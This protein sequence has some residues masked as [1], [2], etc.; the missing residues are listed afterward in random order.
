VVASRGVLY[1]VADYER[2]VPVL[3]QVQVEAGVTGLL[4]ARG[5]TV[6]RDAAL[7]RAGLRHGQRYSPLHIR[8]AT[9]VHHALAGRRSDSPAAGTCGSHRIEAVSQALVGSARRKAR[10][11]RSRPTAWRCC[12]TDH[13]QF[14]CGMNGPSQWPFRQRL[15]PECPARVPRRPDSLSQRHT[16]P[17][18]RQA[19]MHRGRFSILVVSSAATMVSNFVEKVESGQRTYDRFP[20]LPETTAKE[21]GH[22]APRMCSSTSGMAELGSCSR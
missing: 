1:A 19:G 11:A 7:V 12:S 20:L 6:L 22:A 8:S 14:L 17:G 15:R 5:V 9:P 3:T 13:F 2:S 16:E 4:R 18:G 10:K 21:Y